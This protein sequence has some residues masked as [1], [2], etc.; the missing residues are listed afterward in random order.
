MLQARTSLSYCRE[1]QLDDG[2]FISRSA[3]GLKKKHHGMKG[4]LWHHKIINLIIFLN[5]GYLLLVFHLFLNCLQ[6]FHCP[7]RPCN[8]LE[9]FCEGF[10]TFLHTLGAL[11]LRLDCAWIFRCRVPVPGPQSL[12]TEGATGTDGQGSIQT[13]REMSTE[14]SLF[15][16]VFTIITY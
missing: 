9:G 16:S 5:L 1:R 7:S 11:G 8:T 4:A 14:I 3:L 13:G 6:H 10:A 12:I 2:S 15:H